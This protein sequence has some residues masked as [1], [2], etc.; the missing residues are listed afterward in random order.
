MLNRRDGKV[1][2]DQHRT[3]L[4]VADK[5]GDGWRIAADQLTK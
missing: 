1:V 5:T 4:L 2:P 3:L